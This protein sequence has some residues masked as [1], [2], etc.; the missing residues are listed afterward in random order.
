MRRSWKEIGNDLKDRLTD[1]L[2]IDSVTPNMHEHFY[3]G[4]PLYTGHRKLSYNEQPSKLEMLQYKLFARNQIGKRLGQ[5]AGIALGV[6][7]VVIS[8]PL[9][10][11]S[12][13]SFVFGLG[14]AIAEDIEKG[15]QESRLPTVLMF[16]PG[17][18][19]KKIGGAV[20]SLAEMAIKKARHIG[21]ENPAEKARAAE[22][23]TFYAELRAKSPV[24]PKPLFP[25]FK[26]DLGSYENIFRNIPLPREKNPSEIPDKSLLRNSWNTI[27]EMERID[28]EKARRRDQESNIS[29]P[30]SG[31]KL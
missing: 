22:T 30:P 19:G 20:G 4:H 5:I 21:N 26:E 29:P 12:L 31:I 9:L 23:D 15:Y 18:L 8:P 1:V 16:W 13:A 7:A 3:T 27:R 10:A 17:I 24:N 2:Q 14:F 25:I 6:A 28:D 11:I